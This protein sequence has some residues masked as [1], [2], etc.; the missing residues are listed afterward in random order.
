MKTKIKK[1]LA[2]IFAALIVIGSCAVALSA[3]STDPVGTVSVQAKF[4]RLDNVTGEWL[5]TDR[6]KKG[7]TLKARVYVDTD[8]YTTSGKFLVFYDDAFFTEGYARNEVLDVT[9]NPYY[10]NLC[11]MSTQLMFFEKGSKAI[12]RMI[13]NGAFSEEFA[14]T[15]TCVGIMYLLNGIQYNQRLTN[16]EWLVEFDLT[17]KESTDLTEGSVFTLPSVFQSPENVDAF[18]DIPYGKQGE[19]MEDTAGLFAVY[20]DIEAPVNHVS[21]NSN[22]VLDANGGYFEANNANKLTLTA[23]IGSEFDTANAPEP[24][25]G[26]FAFAG[27]TYKG[28]T[29][30]DSPVEVEYDNIELVAQWLPG[31]DVTFWLDEEGTAVHFS[32]TF[33]L[34][35]ELIYPDDP[36]LPG[37][38]FD[39]WSEPEGMELTEDL[40]VFP[41]YTPI[42]Y[43]VTVY[44]L[45]GDVVDEWIAFYGET[46]TADDLYDKEYMD[47][48]LADNG[49]YYTFDYW[50]INGEELTEITVT[51]DVEIE[52]VFTAMDAKLIFDANGATFANGEE[53]VEVILKYD[54]EITAD[55]Y[56]EVPE[57]KGHTFKAWDMDLV[58]QPMDEL[59]KTV[60]ITWT[61]NAYTV[62]YYV[63]NTIDKMISP[64]TYGK[65]VNASVT[66][67]ED[68]IPAGYEFIG[69]SLDKNATVPGDLGTVEGNTNVYAVFAPSGNVA[70]AVEIYKQNLDGE[71]ELSHTEE[72]TD[73]TTGEIPPYAVNNSIEGFSFNPGLSFVDAP[74]AGDGSTV[75]YVY[76]QRNKYNFT[77]YSDGAFIEKHS[78]PYG[79]VIESAD[80][81]TKEGCTFDGWVY[82][83]TTEKADFPFTM[84]AENV[85]LEA[86]WVAT[87]YTVTFETGNGETVS[88][89]TYLF[90]EVVSLPVLTRTGYEFAGWSCNGETIDGDFY[91]PANNVTLK[92]EWTPSNNTA[93]IVNRYFMKAD[94]KGYDLTSEERS[95]TTGEVIKITPSA[96]EGFT[97]NSSASRIEGTINANGSS[98]FNLYYDRNRYTFIAYADNEVFEEAKYLYGA[99]VN[100]AG[101]PSKDGYSFENWVY[102]NTGKI[103]TFPFTM[104]AENVEIIATWS[105]NEYTVNFNTDGGEALNPLKVKCGVSFTLPAASKAGYNFAHWEFDG[106]A[107]AAG[108]SFT[109]P[110]G[111]VTLTAVWLLNSNTVTY[112]VGSETFSFDV[113]P[114]QAVPQPDMSDKPSIEII[115]WLD[116]NGNEAAIPDVMPEN[117]LVFTAKIRYNFS[118]NPYGITVGYEGDCFDYEGDELALEVKNKNL[119]KANGGIYFNDEN[120]KQLALYDISFKYGSSDVQPSG[121]NKVKVSIP[122]PAAYADGT[123]F[124]VINRL[125]NGATEYITVTKSGEKLEFEV[126]KLGEFEI[127][128]KSATVILTLPKTSYIYREALNL[129]GLTLEVVDEN[130]NKKVVDDTSLMTVNNYN[131]RK[132]GTQTLTVEYDG[133]S[134]NFNVSVKYAWWQWIIRILLLGFLWY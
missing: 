39:A 16:D 21:T 128:V 14:Q 91:M 95:G 88:P 2:L 72:Y 66:P 80:P 9:P 37:Y 22:I 127:C 45:Y 26:G 106:T 38:I 7:E 96:V 35:S 111:D 55:M 25:R 43:I 129:S 59:E 8:Y 61:K 65:P 5:E 125:S 133:T 36:S 93:Y 101:T 63:G 15:H 114:G 102:K 13:A 94:G 49:D 123:T 30:V 78:Y 116:A 104:P 58:G 83:G 119:S 57:Y 92:A 4:F 100:G 109:M 97:F 75:L 67:S 77:T 27:W 32:D 86:T 42:E 28:G 103:V 130:G 131:P 46:V 82:K 71:Y 51:G 122:V 126:N 12:D 76:Y 3:L 132:T 120:Y 62:S 110:A 44:G 69:W 24:V 23:E 87:E 90:G 17:V 64:V 115:G 18:S 50:A 47:E 33:A 54:E 34:G 29:E 107:Y 79:K 73:G 48:M 10:K 99:S 81:L 89:E 20:V 11:R 60:S 117:D 98:N 108:Q 70:Y 121:S 1:S 124:L 112:T 84:P 113:V 85:E 68:R 56:P 118:D 31:V 6:A 53:T 134:V 40:E 52:G 105:A 41:T 74:V 19:M